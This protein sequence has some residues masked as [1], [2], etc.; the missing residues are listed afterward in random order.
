MPSKRDSHCSALAPKSMPSKIL[1]MSSLAREAMTPWQRFWIGGAGSLLPLLVTLLAVDISQIIDHPQSI[2]PGVYISAILRYVVFFILGGVVAWLNSD[3]NKP[4]KLVQL[5]IGAPAIISSLINAAPP[6]QHTAFLEQH[7]DIAMIATAYANEAHNAD[8]TEPQI[9]LAGLFG[10]VFKGA[11]RSLPNAAVQGIAPVSAKVA[12]PVSAPAGPTLPSIQFT[13][14]TLFQVR[15]A[16]CHPHCSADAGDTYTFE[17]KFPDNLALVETTAH[18]VCQG[19]GALLAS[20]VS[21]RRLHARKWQLDAL[22][23]VSRRC[24]NVCDAMCGMRKLLV[25]PVA[26]NGY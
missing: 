20:S 11:T 16:K 4:I 23:H 8:Q 21:G 9:Q 19:N 13:S 6:V 17:D 5:G 1:A 14:P 12:A 24:R 2:T 15:Q 22:N 18:V 26:K 25:W 3:E 7:I 10:D